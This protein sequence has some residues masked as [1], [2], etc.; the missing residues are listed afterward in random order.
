VTDGPVDVLLVTMPYSNIHRPSI[1]LGLLKA[2]LQ[3]T[4]ITCGVE[5]A[6]LRFAELVGLDVTGLMYFTRTDSLIGEWTFAGAAFPEHPTTAE[7]IL[8]KAALHQTPNLPSTAVRDRDFAGTFEHVRSLAPRF[9]DETAE[10]VLARRPRLVGCTSTFEQQTASLALLRRIKALDPSVITMLGGANCEAEMGWAVIR[11]FPWVDYVVSGEAEGLFPTLCRLALDRGAD[12]AADELPAGVLGA[13]HVRLDAYGPGRAP[14]PR[15]VVERFDDSPVPDY[16]EY[17]AALA[18][19]SLRAAVTPALVIETSRG[20][21][22]GQKSQCTFCGLNGTGMAYRSKSPERVLAELQGQSERYGVPGFEVADNILDMHHLRTV[23]PELAH[24]GAPYRLFYETKANLR[25]DQVAAMA[26]AG[27]TRMQPGIEALHDGLL[28]LMAK[29]NS[30]VINVQALKYAREFGMC[31]NW[32]LLVNFPGEEAHWHDEVAEWLPML[33]HLQPPGAVVHIRFDR[34]SV[35]HE[36]PE[37][38]GLTLVPYPSYFSVY[39]L[40]PEQMR[41]LAYFFI[42]AGAPSPPR[43]APG[44]EALGARVAEW[45][46]LFH[47]DLRPVLCMTVEDGGVHFL[48]TRPCAPARRTTIEGLDAE[49]YLACDPAIGEMQLVERLARADD[50]AR[51]V[52]AVRAALERLCALKVLLHRHGKYLGLAVAGDLPVIPGP[53]DYPGGHFEKFDSRTSRSLDEAWAKLRR[54]GGPGPRP[55]AAVVSA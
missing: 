30:T 12:V 55:P 26:A 45:K 16:T 53:E 9:V 7:D 8:G 54:M 17:F 52:E 2:S 23:I 25:R 5:Y 11:A 20:C 39:P 36:H 33:Y 29:G 1:A 22:W 4:G 38:Y 32:Y 50:P 14:V 31:C 24:R 15:A 10:R 41:D 18:R 21:W 51:S 47:R 49:A 46:A 28:K 13:V 44:A 27:I 48:D 3:G 43:P 35:Y 40:P 42:D 6:N 19:S 37:R 34:F